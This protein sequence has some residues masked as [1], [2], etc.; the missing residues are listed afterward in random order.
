MMKGSLEDTVKRFQEGIT[1]LAQGLNAVLPGHYL[2]DLEHRA[3]SYLDDGVPKNLALSIAG[4]VNLASGTDIVM[5]AEQRGL[6][7]CEVAKLYFAIG[8]RF[9]LGRLRAAC[10]MVKG[11]SH[12]QKLAIAA[13]I[14]EVFGHQLHLT[15]HVLDTSKNVTDPDKAIKAWM[16]AY[17]NAIDR[18]EQLLT[19][20]WAG[21]I[22][23]ISMI[24]VASRALKSLTDERSG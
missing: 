20:L 23:D 16:D 4:M 12:W 18:T 11:E 24:A 7:V 22:T 15:A 19:E 3:K 9:R 14:E 1:T 5:L 13:L 2:K 21:D 17:Q 8:S 10:E 6:K